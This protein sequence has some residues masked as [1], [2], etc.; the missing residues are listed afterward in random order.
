MMLQGARLIFASTPEVMESPCKDIIAGKYKGRNICWFINYEFTC[1]E[2]KTIQDALP[3]LIC[4]HRIHYRPA[5]QNPEVLYIARAAYGENSSGFKREIMGTQTTTMN[6][7]IHKHLIRK[8]RDAPF[9]PLKVKPRYIFVSLDPSGSTKKSESGMCSDYAFVT[10]TY[11]DGGFLVSSFF[12]FSFVLSHLFSLR[13][14][15]G[16]GQQKLGTLLVGKLLLLALVLAASVR[17]R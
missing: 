14:G 7:F 11:I 2:C 12:L 6:A 10:G 9:K 5:H 15:G 4:P 1:P 8:M 17:R 13:G 16:G 3:G